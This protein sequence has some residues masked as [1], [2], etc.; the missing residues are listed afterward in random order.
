MHSIATARCPLCEAS[1][2]HLN[3][4]SLLPPV[5]TP[6]LI[7]MNADLIKV[8][9]TAYVSDRSHDLEYVTETGTHITGKYRWTYQ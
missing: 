2:V 5:R 4:A 7:E 3:P 6:L 8:E 9:R 1:Q